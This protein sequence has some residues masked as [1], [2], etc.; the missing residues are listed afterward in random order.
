MN[1]R[2][3][4][5]RAASPTRDL[6]ACIEG[7]LAAELLCPGK[8]IMVVSPWMSDF[9]AL[10]NRGGQFTAIEQSWV[11][12]M[13]PFSAV[14][15]SL[16]ARGV[17]VRLAC[18]PGERE[19][20]LVD[21]LSQGAALDGTTDQ[22]ETVRLSQNRKVFSHEKA[23]VADSWAIYGSMNLTKSGVSMNGELITVTTDSTMVTTVSTELRG[24]FA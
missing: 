16:L 19:S 17:D 4:H 1:T 8:N 13:V 9:A 23:L 22:L 10:D 21:R 6:A 15:R 11:A 2:L 12:T 5:R 14:L 7:M 3:I 20:E 24:L 18:G